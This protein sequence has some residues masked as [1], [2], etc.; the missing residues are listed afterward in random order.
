LQQHRSD[1]WSGLFREVALYGQQ[2]DTAEITSTETNQTEIRFTLTDK[3]LDA[4]YDFPLTIKVRGSDAW[5][6]LEAR[7]GERSVPVSQIE[8][9]GSRYALIRAVPDRG[10]IVLRPASPQR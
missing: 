5:G 2:R 4:W 3:M 9:Q 7:Q 6:R 1:I 8:H 10:R